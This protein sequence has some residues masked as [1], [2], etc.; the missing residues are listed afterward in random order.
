MYRPESGIAEE[1]I[2][3]QVIKDTLAYAD[4]NKDNKELI[5]SIIEIAKKLNKD[6]NE[7]KENFKAYHQEEQTNKSTIGDSQIKMIEN[8]LK[9]KKEA[10]QDH[11]SK[12][13]ENS[14]RKDN[15]KAQNM[16]KKNNKK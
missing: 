12:K 5:L 8:A 15:K 2:D 14:K 13:Q 7:I 9:P 4:A 16:E 10:K 1:F 11:N 3:D 6:K